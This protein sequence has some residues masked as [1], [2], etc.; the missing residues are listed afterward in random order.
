[1]EERRKVL[2]EAAASE[3]ESGRSRSTLLFDGEVDFVGR[4]FWLLVRIKR[5]RLMA[6]VMIRLGPLT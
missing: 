6:M 4:R 1:M 3:R 2:L 5:A